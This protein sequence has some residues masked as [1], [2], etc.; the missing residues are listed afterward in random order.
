MAYITIGYKGETIAGISA[1]GTTTLET[2]GKYCEDDI[3][4]TFSGGSV[5]QDSSIYSFRQSTHNANLMRLKKIIG[6]TVAWN[7]LANNGSASVASGHKYIS[8]S[9]GTWSI[10]TSNG[11][12]ISADMVFDITLMFGSTIADYI[13][14]LG[15]ASCVAWFRTL[16]SSASYPYDVGSLLSV[17]TSAHRMVGF[18]QWDEVWEVGSLNGNGEPYVAYNA[19]RSKNF[20]RCLPNTAYHVRSSKTDMGSQNRYYLKILW[21]DADENFISGSWA[22]NRTVTSPASAAYFKIHT[23]T[24][25]IVYGSTYLHDI[26]INISDASLNGT[27]QP[28]CV[29]NYALDSTIELRGIPK[30]DANNNLYYDGDEY[31]PNGN[32]KRN[33]GTRAYQSGDESDSS[34]L[35]D[36]TNTIYKLSTPTT[37]S[38]T[39]YIELQATFPDGTEEFVDARTVPMPVSQDAEYFINENS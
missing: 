7:Q 34:V 12:A 31:T 20:R 38:A 25:T 29:G 9:S 22:N 27:Y 33:Y 30:L 19:I 32:I 24:S 10:G 13:Y 18:N 5:T 6:G 3:T 35:T 39:P 1:S 4:I 17:K 16:F 15:S 11:T 2:A 14:G 23:N 26:C 21:Y 28:Y 37:E 36:G 8:C